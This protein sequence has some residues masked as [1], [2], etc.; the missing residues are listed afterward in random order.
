MKVVT[1]YW[2]GFG[3][4]FN[5]VTQIHFDNPDGV[6]MAFAFLTLAGFLIFFLV[7]TWNGDDK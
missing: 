1:K 3:L 5:V 7:D 4:F 6:S 2:I